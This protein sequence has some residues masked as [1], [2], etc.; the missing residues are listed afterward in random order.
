M[1][2]RRKRSKGSLHLRKEKPVEYVLDVDNNGVDQ[3][4]NQIEESV[5][6]SLSS[7]VGIKQELSFKEQINLS[8]SIANV[9]F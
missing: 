3:Y 7:V 1:R 8:P 4:G 2:S 5:E 6:M 9:T